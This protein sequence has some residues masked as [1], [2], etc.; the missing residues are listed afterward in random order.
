M[1]GGSCLKVLVLDGFENENA[2]ATLV[3]NTVTSNFIQKAAEVER[4]ELR[5]MKVNYCIGCFGCWLKTP[6]KCITKDS[7]DYM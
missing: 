7:F 1:K 4:L 6:G 3:Y 5:N 2:F